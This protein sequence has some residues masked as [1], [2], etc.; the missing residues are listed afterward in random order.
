MTPGPSL[1]SRVVRP[2]IIGRWL[3]ATGY[4]LPTIALVVNLAFVWLPV[5][6]GLGRLGGAALFMLTV[7]PALAFGGLSAV[8]GTFMVIVYART[9]PGGMS[10][11]D[12]A[13]LMCGLPGAVAAIGL[14][15]FSFLEAIGAL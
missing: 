12:W 3:I 14:G 1:P 9:Q 4:I 6:R 5:G 13:F 7:L 11:K 15:A 8:A 2:S 10:W